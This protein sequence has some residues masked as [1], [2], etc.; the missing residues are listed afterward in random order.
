MKVYFVNFWQEFEKL[1]RNDPL[2]KWFFAALVGGEPCATLEEADL[3]ITSVFGNEFPHGKIVV[4]FSGEAYYWA[5]ERFRAN[6]LCERTGENIICLPF[7]IAYLQ[8][9]PRALTALT[10]PRGKFSTPPQKFCCFIVSNPNC[11]VRNRM[12]H[13]LSKW[14][15]VDSWGRAFNNMGPLE[16]D[17]TGD[18]ILEII[19][20]Y[21]FIICFENKWAGNYVTEK[22]V[23]PFLVGCVPVYWG[24]EHALD[25][26]NERAMIY[27]GKREP[28]EA[29][30]QRC[31]E[32]IVRLDRD[33]AAYLK[34]RAET[35]LRDNRLPREYSLGQLKKRIALFLGKSAQKAGES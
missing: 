29:D 6:L 32:E 25:I 8:S 18:R 4:Q 33:D 21:K 30:I 34:M 23:N 19:A 3:V 14:K 5:P 24:S 28:S 31:C 13:A 22:I 1:T 16:G 11:T 12:F 2:N 9:C 10:S 17:W 27:L 35:P 15:R 7:A 26:F 20:Q